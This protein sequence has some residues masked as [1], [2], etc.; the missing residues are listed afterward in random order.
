MVV[1]SIVLVME[2]VVVV[3]MVAVPGGGV[4]S[5]VLWHQKL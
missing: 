2:V 1:I 3:D 5:T 4:V